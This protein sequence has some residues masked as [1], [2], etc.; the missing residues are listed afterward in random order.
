[1]AMHVR[2][3][4][5]N[6]LAKQL[7]KAPEVQTTGVFTGTAQV[8]AVRG[9]RAHALAE[10]LLTR[11]CLFIQTQ[12]W[13]EAAREFR[14]A[15]KMEPDYAE[16]F[17]NLGLS[18]LYANKPEESLGELEAA[19]E[20]V[21]GW[22]IPHANLGLAYQRLNKYPESAEHY[23][24]SVLKQKKQPAVWLAL[25]DVLGAQGKTDKALEA[26]ET[27]L[28][29]SSNY[30]L[31]YHRVGMIHARRNKI[32]EARE[33]LGRA[34]ELEPDNAEA[35]AVLGA[36]AA[37]RGEFNDAQNYF[38]QI[39]ADLEKIPVAATRGVQRLQTF[40]K[41]LTR[42]LGE[43]KASITEVPPLA[44]C[45]YE[46]GLAL[47]LTGNDSGAKE[48]FHKA[49]DTEPNWADPL[50]WFGFYSALDGDG[51]SARKYWETALK[52][53]PR[54]GVLRE[55]LGYLS[56]AMGLGKEAE[57]YFTE[58]NKLGRLIPKEDLAALAQ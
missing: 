6:K 54:N 28:S 58:A 41:G 4:T 25:G 29:L 5:G 15:I 56:M 42:A 36:I 53:E 44:Q 40:R 3:P 48:A 16:A 39:P 8:G 43:R 34:V 1:M 23:E 26:Y 2:R 47:V 7:S 46:L 14:K 45:Y 11:G 31:A 20:I 18:L 19:L 49:S 35:L 57:A 51:G 24:K 17:N 21:P 12:V 50:V 37:R 10:E 9:K 32:D 13:D 55:Q 52:L 30:A 38:A 22:Y 33:A 27:A